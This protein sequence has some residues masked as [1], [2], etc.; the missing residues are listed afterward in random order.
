MWERLARI[1]L[2]L[3]AVGTV[4]GCSGQKIP[5]GGLSAV[6]THG[7]SETRPVMPNTTDAGRTKNRR[8]EVLVTR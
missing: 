3:I 2:A 8:V 5:T 6:T 1:V 7:Y 4:A